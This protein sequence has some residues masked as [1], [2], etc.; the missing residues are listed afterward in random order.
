MNK[1]ARRSIAAPGGILVASAAISVAAGAFAASAASA[2]CAGFEQGADCQKNDSGKNTHNDDV[3]HDSSS[4]EDNSKL[5]M[6]HSKA[7]E[8]IALSGLK[9]TAPLIKRSL[10]IGAL[11][12]LSTMRNL[13]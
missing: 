13:A 5:H 11:I 2:G 1:K 6:V 12:F 8:L 9:N 7:A 3:T 4:F 10:Y